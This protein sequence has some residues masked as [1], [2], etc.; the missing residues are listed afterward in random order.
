MARRR[1]TP[2]PKLSADALIAVARRFR[3]LSD[4]TRLA[5]LQE[6]MQGERTVGELTEAAETSQANASKQLAALAA[7]GILGRRKQGVRVYYRIVDPSISALCELVCG[8]LAQR[9][10]AAWA[11]V[12]QERA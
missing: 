3:A 4:P 8:S 1:T 6:L 12:A 2:K 10:Q 11:L 5:L 9:H 7:E